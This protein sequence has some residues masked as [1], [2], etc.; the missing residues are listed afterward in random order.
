[1]FEENS[2]YL[3]KKLIEEKVSFVVLD[4]QIYLPTLGMVYY[5]KR[6]K[7]LEKANLEKDY[8][9]TPSEQSLVLYLIINKR[10]NF[11]INSIAKELDISSMSVSRAAKLLCTKNILKRSGP[12]NNL[13]F[14]INGTLETLYYH[15]ESHFI[16]PVKKEF[17]ISKNHY[18]WIE[19]YV[20]LSGES[21]LSQISMLSEPA[22]RVFA[23]EKKIWETLIIENE[24]E[25]F[26]N[27]KDEC[28]IVEV[29]SHKLIKNSENKLHHLLLFLSL[30]DHYDERVLKELEKIKI[31]IEMEI[32]N[33]GTK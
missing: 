32:N 9:F 27:T 10:N 17:Y 25:Y 28:I 31:D 18:S 19:K 30:K 20:I 33:E 5:K 12:S 21:L 26:D 24:V 4:M 8:S 11:Q 23:I 3:R 6:R 2:Q 1:V 14:S 13:L 15:A 29:Y 7:Y 22:N 16:N